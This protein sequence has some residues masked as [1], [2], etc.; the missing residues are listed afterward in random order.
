MYTKLIK[1]I[2]MLKVDLSYHSYGSIK[3]FEISV[4]NRSATNKPDRYL[5]KIAKS[6][7]AQNTLSSSLGHYVST[8]P[9]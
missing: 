6:E 3:L 9:F 7:N 8:T 5:L 1:N 4:R 2:S